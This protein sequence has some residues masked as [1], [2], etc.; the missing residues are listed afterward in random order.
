MLTFLLA[1]VIVFIGAPLILC[2]IPGLIANLAKRLRTRALNRAYYNGYSWAM[3]IL[4]RGDNLAPYYP[5]MDMT[6]TPCLRAFDKGVSEALWDF[7][8][9]DADAMWNAAKHGKL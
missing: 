5:R 9:I 6:Q 2:W 7:E 8:R 3:Q 1:C 4:H